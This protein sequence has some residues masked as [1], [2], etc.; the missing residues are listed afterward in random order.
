[1]SHEVVPELMRTYPL[2]ILKPPVEIPGFT[3]C[4]GRHEIHRNDTGHRGLREALINS[5]K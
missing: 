3:I 4:Q 5:A 1:M 2:K